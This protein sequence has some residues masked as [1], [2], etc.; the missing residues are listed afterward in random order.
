MTAFHEHVGRS[1]CIYA[2]SCCL[3]VLDGLDGCGDRAPADQLED[4]HCLG[5]VGG[6]YCSPWEQN[7]YD[8]SGLVMVEELLRS[9]R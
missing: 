3:H 9:L 5:D 4:S 6:H 2:P 7:P 1:Q 8:V